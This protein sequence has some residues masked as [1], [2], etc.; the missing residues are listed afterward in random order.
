MTRPHHAPIRE[1]HVSPDAAGALLA[2]AARLR[3]WTLDDRQA[4]ELALLTNGG[5]APLRGY[6]TQADHQ[7][8]RDG[9]VSP[10]PVPLALPVDGALACDVQPGD[11]IALRDAGGAVLAILSVTDKWG[12]PVLL[13][14]KVKGLG[15]P[16]GGARPNAL[17]ALF[18]DRG[19]ERV[20]AIQPDRS[21]QIEAASDLSKRL[22]ALLLVQPLPGVA[23][24]VPDGAVLAPLPVAPPPGSQGVLWRGM[25]AGNHGATHLVLADPAARRFYRT[26]QDRIGVRLAEDGRNL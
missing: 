12:D 10:W 19:A 14:G 6:M 17:R 3:A 9:A 25:V 1:L 21:D 23:V 18:R 15:R 22:D 4:G 7:A 24:R 26:H 8:V 20:L 16:S 5:F 2:Q 11:D 13:G